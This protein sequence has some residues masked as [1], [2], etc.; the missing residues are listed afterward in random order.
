M[1]I[2]RKKMLD[3]LTQAGYKGAATIEDVTKFLTDQ[4][5]NGIAYTIGDTTLSDENGAKADAVKSAWATMEPVTLRLD[6]AGAK[7]SGTDPDAAMDAYRKARDGAGSQAP[8]APAVH[9]AGSF[10][11]AKKAYERKI[12]TGQAAYADADTAE[13]ATA[14]IRLAIAGQKV[15]RQ[16]A[17]DLDILKKANVEYQNTLGGYL[18]PSDFVAQLLYMTEPYGVA[19]RIANVTRMSRDVQ[20]FPRKTGNQAMTWISENA[21]QTP[22]QQTYD[23][24]NLTAG[25]LWS[26]IQVSNELLEDS[27]ISVADDY[28]NGVREQ[29]DKGIDEAYFIGDGTSTYGGM[30]GLT[31]ALPA[32]AYTT[33]AAW[34]SITSANIIN[35]MGLVENVDSNRLRFLCS[36]QFYFQVL[37]RLD[38]ATSQFRN[39]LG[40]GTG[41]GDAQ[42]LGYPVHFSQ[43]MAR[44][45]VAT[46]AARN[47]YFGDFM[48]ASMIGERRDLTIASSEHVKFLDDASVF[49]ATARASV[50]I[51]GDG[52]GSTYGPI[53]CV[54]GA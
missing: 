17:A 6:D 45:S 16:R 36:R 53:V 11:A 26:S 32:S 8:Q 31:S 18:V 19:R 47:L 29:Y 21:T 22:G 10:S 30:T 33:G 4:S 34:A 37:L 41:G 28:A 39:L 27:A 24:V 12:A 2:T 1:G 23:Q 48:G 43:V 13:A 15:Y 9:G 20:T 38:T 51:H 44:T 35:A 40:P 42:W 3:A 49:R 52:R 5:A 50:N 7:A 46:S 14:G 54:T 25:K